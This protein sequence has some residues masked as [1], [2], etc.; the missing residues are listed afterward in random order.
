VVEHDKKII[1]TIP[2]IYIGNIFF[3]RI[4]LVVVCLYG[5]PKN[6]PSCGRPCKPTTINFHSI[7]KTIPNTNTKNH[8]ND[9]SLF[10]HKSWLLTT[11]AVTPRTRD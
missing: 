7:K 3:Y 10:I 1:G 8:A 5:L 11:V 6:Y 4:K 2:G 9:L